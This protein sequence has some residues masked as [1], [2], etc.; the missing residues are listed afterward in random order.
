VGAAVVTAQVLFVTIMVM[1]I[2]PAN[3]LHPFV[4]V[5]IL[6]LVVLAYGVLSRR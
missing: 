6:P 2:S 5:D 4:V 3:P 1:L